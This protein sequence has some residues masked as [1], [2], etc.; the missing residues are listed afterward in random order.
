MHLSYSLLFEKNYI[1]LD[2]LKKLV[3]EA[4][5]WFK[6]KNNNELSDLSLI[7]KFENRYT[8][9]YAQEINSKR[10][11]N[12]HWLFLEKKINHIGLNHVNDFDEFIKLD[13]AIMKLSKSNFDKVIKWHDTNCVE[14]NFTDYFIQSNNKIFDVIIKI[15]NH[16]FIIEQ[17]IINDLGGT[18]DKQILELVKISG[19]YAKVPNYNLHFVSCLSGFYWEYLKDTNESKSR[20]KVLV[21]NKNIIKNL[22]INS[23]NY[24]LNQNSLIELIKSII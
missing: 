6:K 17:K 22:N 20:N 10:M 16:I 23:N 24:F 8:E 14:T 7:Q 9:L 12:S 3:L 15:R 1:K 2:I 19:L 5:K 21:Q 4:V 18:Q 11:G 13:C